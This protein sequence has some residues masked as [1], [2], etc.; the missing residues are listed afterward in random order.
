MII[1]VVMVSLLSC[2]HYHY[3]FIIIIDTAVHRIFEEN[4][5]TFVVIT[6]T[7]DVLALLN[8]AI[9]FTG[10]VVS[11]FGYIYGIFTWKI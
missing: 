3:H 2:Y 1:V 6:V 8:S 10:V 5:S 9:T 4:M 7:V 11:K